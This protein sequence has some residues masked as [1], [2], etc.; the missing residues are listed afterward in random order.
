MGRYSFATQNVQKTA[1][2]LLH[3]NRIPA[4]PPWY[5]AIANT[6]P[7]TRLTRPPLQRSNAPNKK[8]NRKSS[9]LFKPLSIKYTEDQLRWE[10]FNDHPWELARPRVVLEDNGRDREVYDWSIPLDYSLRRPR[11]GARDEFGRGTAEWEEVMK[12]QGSRPING[13]AVVQRWQYLLTHTEM[14]QAAAYDQ[15]RKE[16]YRYRHHREVEARVAREEAQA[17]GAYFGL[18]PLEVGDL[19]EDKAFEDWKQWAIKQTQEL[20]A[21]Q[22]SAYTGAEDGAELQLEE[23]EAD[24]AL[25]EVS[26]SVPASRA[27]QTARGGAPVRP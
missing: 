24:A 9:R 22:S 25:Q 7:S 12:V 27:G 19:L 14:T 6:P 1:S 20:K 23:P 5:Q 3:V 18:G 2:Q 13:E 4:P 21:M 15:A 26:S 10:Y 11:V 8:S 17:T 16:L